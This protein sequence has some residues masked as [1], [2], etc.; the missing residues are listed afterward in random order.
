MKHLL[1]EELV[2]FLNA[3]CECM[4]S[5]SPRSAGLLQ[6]LRSAVGQLAWWLQACKRQQGYWKANEPGLWESLEAY[7]SC[8]FSHPLYDLGATA[9]A[10]LS[11]TPETHRGSFKHKTWA[12]PLADPDVGKHD[13][14]ST[15]DLLR[16][17]ENM[18]TRRLIASPAA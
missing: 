14:H 7:L 16:L 17:G 18:S 11:S 12:Q 5:L 2:Y 3:S 1:L 8:I 10:D 6:Q 9:T 15:R 4:R 13:H